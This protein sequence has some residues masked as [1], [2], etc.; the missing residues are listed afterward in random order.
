MNRDE[1]F[2]GVSDAVGTL[3]SIALANSL[4]R[5]TWAITY[6]KNKNKPKAV[7]EAEKTPKKE[8]ED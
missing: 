2:K 4:E 7:S 5:L 3:A 6:K 1:I 8:E